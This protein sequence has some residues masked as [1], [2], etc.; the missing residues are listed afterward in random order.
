MKR[1]IFLLLTVILCAALF[2]PMAAQAQT[3]QMDETD[4]TITVNDAEWYVF[5]RDNI[6]DNPE[7]AELGVT[8]QYMYDF[9]QD[10]AAYLD[11]ILFFEEG[12]YLEF[13]VQKRP[14]DTGVANLS[15]YKD[16]EV[17]TFAKE[18]AKNAKVEDY[19]VYKN[20]YKFVKLSFYDS[21]L[22]FYVHQYVTIVNKNTYTFTFQSE[23]AIT[24]W[25]DQEIQRIV[26]SVVFDVDTSLKEK[27]GSST[28]L[29]ARV[30]GGG[31][32]GGIAGAIIGIKNK[33]KKA[34]KPS[35]EAPVTTPDAE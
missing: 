35:E 15:N 11:A 34:D 4:M 3:Y 17:S 14:L 21:E 8:Y 2:L 31:V 7:L 22:K 16:S 10:N 29:I 27:T 23:D 5:T 25:E 9:F 6:K 30:I 18:L 33:K 20:T 24:E 12:G 32:A 28:S 13:F 1:Q 19:S 26:D